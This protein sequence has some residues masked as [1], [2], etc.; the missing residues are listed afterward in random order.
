MEVYNSSGRSFVLGGLIG[1]GGE[2]TVYGVKDSNLAVKIY[3]SPPGEEKINKINA[4]IK[5]KNDRLLSI[6][7]WPVDTVHNYPLGPAAGIFMPKVSGFKGIHKLYSP[8]SRM[9]E[10]PNAGWKFL[11]HAAANLA[12]A[13][14]VLHREGHVIGDINHENIRVSGKAI[15]MLIDCDSFQVNIDG[16][17]Y[18]CTVG[19]NI[20][21]PPEL[22]DK[23]S[24]SEI[25]WTKNHDA[26]GLAVIIFQLLFMGRHPFSE[27]Y[28]GEDDMPLERAISEKRFSYARSSILKKPSGALGSD[29]IPDSLAC[30]F[31]NAFLND[32]RPSDEDWIA[33]L[34]NLLKQ[35][36][37]CPYNPS[38]RFYARLKECPWCRIEEETGAVLF[39]PASGLSRG[40]GADVD[41]IWRRIEETAVPK[42]PR[43]PDWKSIEIG[44]SKQY[45]EYMAKKKAFKVLSG[46]SLLP[47]LIGFLVPNMVLLG[48]CG[49]GASLGTAF[50]GFKPVAER[51]GIKA[52]E[53]YDICMDKLND[54]LKS[55]KSC[56]LEKE[57]SEKKNELER[58][59][60]S[61]KDIEKS[62]E[63]LLKD[64][65]QNKRKYQLEKFLGKYYLMDIN[66]KSISTGCKA[67]LQAYGIRTAADIK[68]S[69]K[70]VPNLKP[71][72][73]ETLLKWR[74]S[75]ESRF[76]FNPGKGV[77]IELIEKI[78]RDFLL[79]KDR[80][81]GALIKGY[82][83]LTKHLTLMA[84][85]RKEM[86]SEV[87][88]CSRELARASENLKAIGYK[89]Q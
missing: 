41:E 71:G 78:D 44:P 1:K 21:Q 67:A 48:I 83:D 19:V 46:A 53:K 84:E 4:M 2:G 62:R 22:Q 87:E 39:S 80:I 13:F 85:K 11:I 69:L 74:K 36:R 68:E 54:S 24:F 16:V 73:A 50:A 20:Y 29:E 58:L 64:I 15:I 10:F 59:Y 76:V 65:H 5:C 26:F 63:R 81:A 70:S 60:R 56:S 3:N 38:H 47:A 86:F 49:V 18:P 35:L 43:L 72:I 57:T 9:V 77:D 45:K 6:S 31:E 17:K 28:F 82:E 25:E 7:S 34:Q 37:L 79:Q 55:W 14:S 33:E 75:L 66:I 51:V 32:V 52:K 27:R 89:K 8:K 30:L 42:L 88:R 12:R 40:K 61:Y 23:K